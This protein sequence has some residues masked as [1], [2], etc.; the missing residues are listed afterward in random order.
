MT[1]ASAVIF[2]VTALFLSMP[3]LTGDVSVLQSAS[4]TPAEAPA[5]QPAAAPDTN[6]NASAPETTT[7]SNG[8]LVETPATTEFKQDAANANAAN[9]APANK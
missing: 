8:A 7:N 5:E 1:I 4:E 3:A 2:L 6:A 9:S